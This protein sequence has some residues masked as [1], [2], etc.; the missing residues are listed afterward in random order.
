MSIKNK[1]IQKEKGG[2]LAPGTV[3]PNTGPL[4]CHP[5]EPG[6]SGQL[7][8]RAHW[9]CRNLFPKLLEEYPLPLKGYSISRKNSLR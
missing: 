9:L 1:T 3:L 2:K 7:L 5:P 4:R 8:S 6:G